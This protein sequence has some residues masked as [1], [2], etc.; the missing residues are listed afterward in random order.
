MSIAVVAQSLR[1]AG[2]LCPLLTLRNLFCTASVEGSTAGRR[3]DMSG[4]PV[5]LL[6]DNILSMLV[7]KGCCNP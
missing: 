1:K 2:G 4:K 5:F 6:C 3:F 7:T